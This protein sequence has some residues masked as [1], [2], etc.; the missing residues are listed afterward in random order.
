MKSKGDRL[1]WQT[2]NK[3]VAV[4]LKK[5]DLRSREVKLHPLNQDNINRLGE[6]NRK[7][8]P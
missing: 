1:N 5:A 7:L 3:S 6:S 8:V 2:V 4:S